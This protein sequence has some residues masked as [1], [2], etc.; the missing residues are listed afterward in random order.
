MES[1]INSLSDNEESS[2]SNIS[3]E[4]K[5]AASEMLS[6]SKQDNNGE[7]LLN[8]SDKSKSGE[9]NSN[10]Q[11]EISEEEEDAPV[12][13]TVESTANSQE[14]NREKKLNIHITDTNGEPVSGLDLYIYNMSESEDN[15]IS[16]AYG[17]TNID[18]ISDLITDYCTINHYPFTIG[19][20]YKIEII[21]RYSPETEKI[22]SS[23]VVPDDSVSEVSF[24]W[25]KQ[26]PKAFAENY[27]K[28][29]V[30]RIVDEKGNPMPNILLDFSLVRESVSENDKTPPTI[31]NDI[32]TQTGQ[33]TGLTDK[34]GEISLLYLPEGTYKIDY[35]NTR[36][37]NINKQF[38]VFNFTY[39]DSGTEIFTFTLLQ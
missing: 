12:P 14:V 31:I 21:N 22:A 30:I 7:S 1:S 16:R 20:E 3:S 35:A 6:S 15:Y 11:W 18:G 26:T 13:P 23:F 2:Q 4:D 33:K 25:D 24:V 27:E 39:T 32:F 34:N 5:K 10:S 28:K 37:K 38:Q 8:E 9:E 19:K 29:A 36:L 17:I